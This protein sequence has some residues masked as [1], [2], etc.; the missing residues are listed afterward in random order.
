MS[1]PFDKLVAAFNN[2]GDGALVEAALAFAGRVDRHDPAPR[3]ADPGPIAERFEG[4]LAFGKWLKR[5]P[6]GL[7]FSTVGEPQPDGNA[8][9]VEYAVEIEDFKNGGTWRCVFDEDGRAK[10]L[11]HRPFSL[12]E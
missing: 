10:H 12:V 4:W 3:G 9:V 5:S 2:P 6:P 7:R 1:G 11:A 8:L